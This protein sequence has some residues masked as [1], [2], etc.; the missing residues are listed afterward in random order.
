MAAGVSPFPTGQDPNYDLPKGVAM[1]IPSGQAVTGDK[2]AL[3]AD[4]PEASGKSKKPSL[5]K[6]MK[7][8]LTKSKGD[9]ASA[10]LGDSSTLDAVR[11]CS[12]HLLPLRTFGTLEPHGH[13]DHKSIEE[14]APSFHTP[15]RCV[16][17]IKPLR[18]QGNSS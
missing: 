6:R 10:P 18:W 12:P 14:T 9:G 1:D 5:F 15:R 2:R 3:A 16:L 8:K 7:S 4:T 13:G 17:V 11:T